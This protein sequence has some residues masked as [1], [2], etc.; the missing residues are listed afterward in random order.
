MTESRAA[1]RLESSERQ[2]VRPRGVERRNRAQRDMVVADTM[3]MKRLFVAYCPNSGTGL[4]YAWLRC[5]PHI[6]KD[7][8]EV[9]A[10]AR[11]G[12]LTYGGRTLYPPDYRAA[13]ASSIL[14]YPPSHRRC[15]TTCVPQREGNRLT[16]FRMR[17]MDGVG[18][19]SPPVVL[20]VCVRG[21][22]TP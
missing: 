22:S 17:T 18:F 4:S 5:F 19:A 13:F 15:L 2:R 3:P 1:P 20:P 9:S 11:E 8:M 12:L 16:T 14:L 21:A 7:Q 6:T 10:L